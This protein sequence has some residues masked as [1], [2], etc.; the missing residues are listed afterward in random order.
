[1]PASAARSSHGDELDGAG[2]DGLELLVG[3]VTP[4]EPFGVDGEHVDVPGTHRLLAGGERVVAVDD[5]FDVERSGVGLDG[6]GQ[7]VRDGASEPDIFGSSPPLSMEG[8]TMTA[9]TIISIS[10]AWKARERLR[11]RSSRR[12]TSHVWR[13]PLTT[14]PPERT[15][16]TTSAAHMRTR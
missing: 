9:T 12:A 14:P 5:H 6:A 4:F 16:P 1:M 3:V 10:E 2:D 13:A 8:R 11:S 15:A 7:S